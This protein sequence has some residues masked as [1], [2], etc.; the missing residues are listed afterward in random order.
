MTLLAASHLHAN[1]HHVTQL[2]RY[3]DTH[4]RGVQKVLQLNMMHK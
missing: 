1:E 4:T 2:F 3:V